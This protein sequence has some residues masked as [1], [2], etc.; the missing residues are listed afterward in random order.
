MFDPRDSRT[1]GH[2]LFL[3]PTGTL[4][5]ELQAAITDLAKRYDGPIFAPHVTLLA[6][7]ED[8]DPREKV[9]ELASSLTPFTLT[10]GTLDGEDEYFRAFYIHIEH[11]DA[12]KAAHQAALATFSMEDARPYMAH[13]SLFYGNI[14]NVLRTKL[15][16]GTVYPAGTSWQVD[17][18][19]LYETA[20]NA[21]AWRKVG[22]YP[23]GS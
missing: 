16:E 17:S 13:L 1:I 15:M 4:G 6:R 22:E 20:G 3:E 11:T 2:H 9:K 8:E 21:E 5:Q 14:D 7:I 10:L 18:L 23:F 19:S 12:L